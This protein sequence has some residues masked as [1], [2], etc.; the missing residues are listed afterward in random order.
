M[1]LAS[2]SIP[3]TKAQIKVIKAK[4]SAV[5]SNGAGILAQPLVSAL[6]GNGVIGFLIL[7]A[8]SA[9]YVN[10]VIVEAKKP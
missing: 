6:E 7:D 8:V 4:F 10:A 9:R 2:F 1:K 3:L 5:H